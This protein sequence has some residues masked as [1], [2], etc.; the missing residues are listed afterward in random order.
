MKRMILGKLLHLVPVLLLLSAAAFFMLELIPGDPAAAVVGPEGTPERYLQVRSELGLDKPLLGRYAAWLGDA[1]RGDLGSSLVPP[2]SNVRTLIA[3]RLPVTLEIAVL[4]SVLALS[5][6]IPIAMIA[7][8]RA[9]TRVDHAANGIAFV[10]ISVPSFLGGLLLMFFL[11]FQPDM[12]R[13]A[14]LTIGLALVAYFG[15]RAARRARVGAVKADRRRAAAAGAV[16]AASALGVGLLLWRVWPTFPRQ[17]FI[18]LTADE[19]VRENL[20]HA[21]LPALTLALPEAAVFMRLLRADLIT[22]LQEDFILAARAKGMPAWRI[23]LRDAL[24][25]S[26]F[27]LITV[28][29]VVLGRLIGGTLIVEA[30]FGVPG[31]GSLLVDGVRTRDYRVVQGLVLVLAV[32][33]VLINALVDVAYT[34]LDPRVRR[35]S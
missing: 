29:G 30:I 13:I 4:A 15:Q 20:R 2:V 21:F 22:T 9:R 28:A 6:A 17:G 31:I 3:S 25:P 1:V 11:V 14:W 27:S 33:Y 34:Y 12:V 19:G 5:F 23:M 35:G 32:V 7:A 10:L 26:S 8:H 18:R 24:R 16:S